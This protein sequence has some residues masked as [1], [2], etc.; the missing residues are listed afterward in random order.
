MQDPVFQR[1][2]RVFRSYGPILFPRAFI[3]TRQ[4]FPKGD[5]AFVSLVFCGGTALRMQSVPQ[6]I[7]GID[8]M[9]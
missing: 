6:Q 7:A 8:R 4:T 2:A 3:A 1:K 5:F 9:A